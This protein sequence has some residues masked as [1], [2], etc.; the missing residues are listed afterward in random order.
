[1]QPTAR[2]Q[3]P[4]KRYEWIYLINAWQL[5]FCHTHIQTWRCVDVA[6]GFISELD[7]VNGWLAYDHINKMPWLS[8]IMA[9]CFAVNSMHIRVPF[10]YE[11]NVNLQREKEK[12][13]ARKLRKNHIKYRIVSSAWRDIVLFYFC[14]DYPRQVIAS[15][16][17]IYKIF[18]PFT[19]RLGLASMEWSWLSNFPFFIIQREADKIVISFA[20]IRL[21]PSE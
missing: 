15:T 12:I 8:Q 11:Q 19:G 2:I 20:N 4:L 21:I 16:A 7:M 10:N 3:F 6:T 14:F 13:T 9:S 1:M 18:W 17:Q 5:L